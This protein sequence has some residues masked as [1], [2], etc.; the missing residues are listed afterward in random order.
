LH[1]QTSTAFVAAEERVFMRRKNRVLCAVV[2]LSFVLLLSSVP[3]VV[4]LDGLIDQSTVVVA[5]PEKWEMRRSGIPHTPIIIDG[6]T[7]FN[8]TAFSEGWLGNG[9]AENPYII[10]GLDIDRGGAAGHCISISNTRVNFTISNCNLT[11]ASVYPG[12]GVYLYNVS[13]GELFNNT[14]INNGVG[15]FVDYSTPNILTDN[16]CFWNDIGIFISYSPSNT[17][18]NNTCS[19]NSDGF[20]LNQCGYNSVVNNTFTNNINDIYIAYAGDNSI[21][22]NILDSLVNYG[23]NDY[24]YNYWYAYSGSDADGDGF[25]DTPYIINGMYIDEDPHPLMYQPTPPI[26]NETPTDQ[27]INDTELLHYD[28]NAIS[29]AP[30]F[31]SVNDTA[32]F[33]IDDLGVLENATVLLVGSYGLQV[34]V[35]NIYGSSISTKFTVEVLSWDTAP[36]SWVTTPDNQAL[37][38]GD[39]F[40]YDVNA[41]DPSGIDQ[42]WLNRTEFSIDEDG[43]IVNTTALSVNVYDLEISVN[44]TY[45]NEQSII[46]T[47]T[48]EDTTPPIWIEPPTDQ[49]LEF[50][51]NFAY[52]VTAFDLSG[53]HHYEVNDTRFIIDED[54]LIENTT[55]LFVGEY[56]FEVRAF[57]PY[58]LFCSEIIRITVQDTTS[59]VWLTIPSDII[60]NAGEPLEQELW[61]WDLSVIV[62]WTVND[63]A[64]FGITS[65]G[66]LFNVQSLAAGDYGLIVTVYDEYDNSLSATFSVFVR[67]SDTTTTTTTTTTST[68]T[69]TATTTTTTDTTTTGT[70]PEGVDPVMMLVLGTGIGGVAVVIIVIV[71]LRRKS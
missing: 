29:P 42:W 64:N 4:D 61:A 66:R 5:E 8:V 46:I 23:L 41:T 12:S 56:W 62:G 7:N 60:L 40:H 18:A 22:W 65:D 3:S 38:Y 44:D 10:N 14:C 57:D 27:T 58:S 31:W 2:S 50:G 24:D 32:Q 43:V 71:F 25:G 55:V 19:Y 63:T 39:A 59:P 67:Q 13:H 21:M 54:G 52:D 34:V 49:I 37:E 17:I 20:C 51:A 47:I 9:S 48:V 30:I 70:A 68:T 36:P 6:D 69:T 16:D 28:L 15:I 26:W 1:E 33:T 53:V 45:G 35:T 11:G